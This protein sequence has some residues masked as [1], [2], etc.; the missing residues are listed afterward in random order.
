MAL[1]FSSTNPKN[2]WMEAIQWIKNDFTPQRLA[3]LFDDCPDNTVPVK[4]QPYLTTK[5]EE[6]TRINPARYEF[7]VYRH[8][9]RQLNS[10]E[11]FLEDSLQHR[12]LNQELVSLEEKDELIQQLNIPALNKPIK[13]ELDT[14]FAELDQLWATFYKAMRK[15]K[16][17]HLRYDEKNGTLHW[18]KI[19]SDKDERLHHTIYEQLPLCDITD[20]LRFVNKR[21]GFLSAFTH[22]QPRYAQQ[23]AKKDCLIGAIIA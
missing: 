9:N 13:Q 1:N 23:P 17:K 18:H 16:L 14:L 22:L 15:G 5:T 7:W 8:L 11:I 19:K 21:C 20:V 10:G 2:H 6:K 4:L 12:S 3:P